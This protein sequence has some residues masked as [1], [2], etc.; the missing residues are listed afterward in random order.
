MC[1]TQAYVAKWAY[2]EIVGGRGR[3]E[4]GQG[5]SGLVRKKRA[6]GS[7]SVDLSFYQ[8]SCSSFKCMDD[9]EVLITE[10]RK[11]LMT[12][13]SFGVESSVSFGVES[14]VLS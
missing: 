5:R 13:Y 2:L 7:C 4:S 8:R 10:C 14:S 1:I 11:T 3:R 9:K 12:G 6:E